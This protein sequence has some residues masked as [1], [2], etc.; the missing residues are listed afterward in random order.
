MRRET[1]QLNAW[2][3]VHYGTGDVPAESLWVRIKRQTNMV[4]I[5]VGVCYRPPKQEEEVD[6]VFFR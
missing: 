4:D 5:V 3:H 6:E 1:E 2:N